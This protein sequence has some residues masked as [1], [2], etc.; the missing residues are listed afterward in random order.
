MK[1]TTEPKAGEPGSTTSMGLWR[2]GLEYLEAGRIISNEAPRKRF[3]QTPAY[4]LLARSIE[5][6]LKGYLR[7]CGFTINALMRV[8]HVLKRAL[9]R[10][11]EHGIQNHCV[12]TDSDRRIIELVDLTYKAK[13]FEYLRVGYRQLP[14]LSDLLALAD[15]LSKSLEKFCRINRDRSWTIDG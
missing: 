4:F 11:V 12:I 5:L 1:V 3:L 8:N 14:Q 10:A 7:G 15:K 6:S 2:Y 9:A 13:D